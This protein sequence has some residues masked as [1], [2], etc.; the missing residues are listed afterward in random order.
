M[1]KTSNLTSFDLLTKIN[2]YRSALGYGP[3]SK[4]DFPTRSELTAEYRRVVC[5]AMQDISSW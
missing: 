3:I 2:E 5:N 4:Y 1:I